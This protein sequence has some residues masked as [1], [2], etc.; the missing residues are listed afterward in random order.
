[1]QSCFQGAL[2]FFFLS[3]GFKVGRLQV[4]GEIFFSSVCGVEIGLFRMDTGLSMQVLLRSA[5]GGGGGGGW[6][7]KIYFPFSQ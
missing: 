1:L 2:D 7:E 3:F 4:G 6:E 5:W